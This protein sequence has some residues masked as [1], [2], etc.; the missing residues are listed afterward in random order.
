MKISYVCK[1]VGGS[2]AK[3]AHQSQHVGNK[4]SLVATIDLPIHVASYSTAAPEQA[5]SLAAMCMVILYH[6]PFSACK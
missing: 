6:W 5:K 3:E 1:C 4:N 2:K